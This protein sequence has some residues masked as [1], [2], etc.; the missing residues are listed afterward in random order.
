M[1]HEFSTITAS[2]KAAVGRVIAKA[3][4]EAGNHTEDLP[5]G[6]EAY[7]YSGAHGTHWGVNGGP[8]GFNIAR[9]IWPKQ[10]PV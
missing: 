7:A 4:S 5:D 10:Q 2:Q 6:S 3:R 8:H 1:N 9:G